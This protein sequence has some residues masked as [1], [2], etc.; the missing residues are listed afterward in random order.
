MKR[1]RYFLGIIG[2]LLFVCDLDG[3]LSIDNILNPTSSCNGS[4]EITAS[5]TAGPFSLLVVY[6][7]GTE[8][9]ARID[10]ILGDAALSGLCPGEYE[11]LAENRFGCT[12][13]LGSVSL[14]QSSGITVKG[15]D[16]SKS[17]E[18]EVNSIVIDNFRIT[19]FPNPFTQD[20]TIR[21]QADEPHDLNIMITDMVGRKVHEQNITTTKG[22]YDIVI[23]D[24]KDM[25]HGVYM[26]RVTEQ[27]YVGEN[28]DNP[29]EKNFKII[30]TR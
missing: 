21:I 14:I 30:K 1:I 4:I 12:H 6:S 23:E 27:G 15:S 8:P 11:V 24:M 2:A 20:I 16:L 3:Q 5:G 22:T 9:V 25:P 13:F 29:L 17:N 26:V 7:N 28:E 18:V 19:Y 10:S